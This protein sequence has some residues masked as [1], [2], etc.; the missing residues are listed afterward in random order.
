MNTCFCFYFD[1]VVLEPECMGHRVFATQ[2]LRY[3]IVII[4]KPHRDQL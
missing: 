2:K 1:M 3:N 4:D